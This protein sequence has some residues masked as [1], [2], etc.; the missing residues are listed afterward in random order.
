MAWTLQT[1]G[2][3]SAAFIRPASKSMVLPVRS[4]S[5]I[6][7]PISRD[8]N[9]RPPLPRATV[10][11]AVGRRSR[12]P[13]PEPPVFI[14]PRT[15]DDVNQAAAEAAA[16]MLLAAVPPPSGLNVR[17][18]HH[19]SRRPGAVRALAEAATTGA[20]LGLTSSDIISE[21]AMA[22]SWRSLSPESRSPRFLSQH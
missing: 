6:G 8:L 11:G 21:Q 4:R 20:E 18:V 15:L 16:S 1:S 13:V 14:L 22:S 7:G 12:T 10:C 2:T 3:D 19:E 9:L 5:A 17:R